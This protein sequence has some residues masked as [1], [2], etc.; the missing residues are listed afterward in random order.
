[1]LLVAS[2]Y[3]LDTH[4]PGLLHF[5]LGTAALTHRFTPHII[6]S[7]RIELEECLREGCDRFVCLF[8]RSLHLM[9]VNINSE[10]NASDVNV[11]LSIDF[12]TKSHNMLSSYQ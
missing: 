7:H 6:V 5:R 11:M 1:M 4:K 12:P 10:T 8:V 9:C 2:I 3:G